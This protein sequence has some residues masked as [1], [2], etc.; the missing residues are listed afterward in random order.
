M[1]ASLGFKPPALPE[2]MTLGSVVIALLNGRLE[3]FTNAFF[4]RENCHVGEMGLLR[5]RIKRS[6]Q[7]R[8][9]VA[10]HG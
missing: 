8:K 6:L 3:E 10:S 4:E 7:K 9:G 2:V 1:S 5:Q